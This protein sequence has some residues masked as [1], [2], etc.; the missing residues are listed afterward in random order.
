M[1]QNTFASRALAHKKV[2]KGQSISREQVN[3]ALE[4]YKSKGGTITKLPTMSD[5]FSKKLTSTSD[6][7][8]VYSWTF[9]SVMRHGI[10]KQDQLI[11]DEIL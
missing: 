1:G 5:G 8:K 11:N 9:E 2:R 3:K 10:A 7:Y 4:A 6:Y